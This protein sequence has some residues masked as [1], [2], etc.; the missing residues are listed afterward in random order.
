MTSTP[1]SASSL[2]GFNSLQFLPVLTSSVIWGNFFRGKCV[3][4]GKYGNC[5]WFST[6]ILVEFRN[7]IIKEAVPFPN[8]AK[9]SKMNRK[10][11]SG[12]HAVTASGLYPLSYTAISLSSFFGSKPARQWLWSFACRPFNF[13]NACT[14]Y[15]GHYFI[16]QL[17]LFTSR[18]LAWII[19]LRRGMNV[20]DRHN[21]WLRADMKYFQHLL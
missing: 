6:G 1:Q 17:S 14:S 5:S 4:G 18:R 3:L 16:W 15:T 8:C 11:T 10:L 12:N 19:K 7:N 21:A 13:K 20:S 2:Y 9:H